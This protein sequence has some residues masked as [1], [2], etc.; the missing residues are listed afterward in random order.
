MQSNTGKVRTKLLRLKKAGTF[1]RLSRTVEEGYFRGYAL[2]VGNELFMMAV[3][4]QDL[5]AWNGYSILRFSEIETVERDPYAQFAELALKKLR[6]GKP[7]KPSVVAES[8]QKAL[9][10]AAKSFPLV[11]IHH[12]NDDP[13]V[14]WVGAVREVSDTEVLLLEIDPDAKWNRRPRR[15]KLATI[16]RVDFGGGYERALYLVGGRPRTQ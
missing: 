16:T 1:V 3:V 11:T 8:M 5:I 2:D 6:F 12:E 14:C 13:D 10:Q 15:H 4:S 7:K 9:S